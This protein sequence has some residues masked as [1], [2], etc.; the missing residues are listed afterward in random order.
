MTLP[1]L[2]ISV[3]NA[4]CRR[5]DDEPRNSSKAKRFSLPTPS[6]HLDQSWRRLIRTPVP[7]A[8]CSFEIILS[9]LSVEKIASEQNLGGSAT[10]CGQEWNQ[11]NAV[12]KAFSIGKGEASAVS[13]LMTKIPECVVNFLTESVK[14]R[15]MSRYISHDVLAKDVFNTAWTSGING[16]EHWKEQLR[17]TEELVFWMN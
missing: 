12:A 5:F 2:S 4:V 1:V 3:F 9:G 8:T 10:V 13:N 15:G 6:P 11:A 7:G 17:N 16:L 14:C